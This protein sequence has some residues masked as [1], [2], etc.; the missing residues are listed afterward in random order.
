MSFCC[1]AVVL[2]FI[3][4]LKGGEWHVP[5]EMRFPNN[6]KGE[7]MQSITDEFKSNGKFNPVIRKL[8]KSKAEELDLGV[9]QMANLF[10]VNELTMSRWMQG[11]TSYCTV[12]GRNKI[13]S[14]ISGRNDKM[15]CGNTNFVSFDNLGNVVRRDDKRY[16]SKFSNNQAG[17]NGS[18]LTPGLSQYIRGL[19]KKIGETIETY[20]AEHPTPDPDEDP[21]PGGKKD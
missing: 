13:V 9:G 3:V 1:G 18:G 5:T 16:N 11:P 15:I 14:F 19:L 6:N 12:A 8:L 4:G 7:Y 21:T 2:R 10:D 17:S 20:L